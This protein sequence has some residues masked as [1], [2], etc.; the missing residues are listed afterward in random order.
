MKKYL[1]IN[2]KI[3]I[4][5]GFNGA[6]IYDFQNLQRYDIQ[7]KES[8]ILLDIQ[9]GHSIEELYLKYDNNVLNKFILDIENSNIGYIANSF[10]P[11]EDY[12]IGVL[13]RSPLQE[14]Y[15][16]N[17]A[18]VELPTDCNKY[19]KHCD[20]LK[21]NSCYCCS[22]PNNTLNFDL[23][24]YKNLLDQLFCYNVTNIIIH[25]GNPLLN[26]TFT[27]ELL[28]YILEK[29]HSNVCII[30]NDTRIDDSILN[31]LLKNRI[32]LVVNVEYSNIDEKNKFFNKYNYLLNFKIG[33]IFNF[34]VKNSELKNFK[35]FFKD[36]FSEYENITYSI[37]SNEKNFKINYIEDL[38]TQPIDIQYFNNS[39]YY[40][41]CLFGVISI[42]SNKK[43]YPCISFKNNELIDLSK[44]TFE[45]LFFNKDKL[46]EFW[47]ITS[48][49][50]NTCS[51][52]KFNKS[53]IDCRAFEL[54]IGNKIFEKTSCTL[55]K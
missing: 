49:K 42:R 29:R 22:L 45:D 48:S 15:S 4:S 26:W 33:I 32:S 10:I 20:K 38:P 52:C 36:L 2:D 55:I 18:Y 16:L 11:K 30:T 41:P 47:N 39:D 17:T 28:D 12:R 24:F 51:K 34:N 35:I 23:D 43:V 5:Y 19:C 13:K 27:R 44:D 3:Q 46:Y 53:C 50:L 8:E 40:H 54:N 25:G 6:V 21:I 37:Y 1:N 14:S 31:Y 9:K 7:E